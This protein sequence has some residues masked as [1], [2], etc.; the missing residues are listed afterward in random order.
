MFSPTSRMKLHTS[1]LLAAFAIASAVALS[2]PASAADAG[3]VIGACDRTPGCVYS[4]AQDGTLVGCSPNACFVCP[5]DGSH[6]CHAT[7][8]GDKSGRRGVTIGGVKL[9]PAGKEATNVS[10]VK[11]SPAGNEAVN[12][13]GIKGEPTY[14]RGSAGSPSPVTMHGISEH[15]SGDFGHSGVGKH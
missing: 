14:G 12:V 4:Q 13:S 15:P 9:S 11:L 6:Q 3:A 5:H 7:R 8:T 10:G 2:T 1:L